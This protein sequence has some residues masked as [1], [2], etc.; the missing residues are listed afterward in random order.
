MT[1]PP[2]H[3]RLSLTRLF[4]FYAG[5]V[6][7]LFLFSL[8]SH[9]ALHTTVNTFEDITEREF[10][11]LRR[12]FFLQDAMHETVLPVL[13]HIAWGNPGEAQ[14]FEQRVQE[15]EEV[16]AD[17]LAMESMGSEQRELI[18]AAR[19]HW[20]DGVAVGRSMFTMPSGDTAALQEAEQSF[21]GHISAC[22]ASLY[23]AHNVRIADTTR[24]KEAAIEW[25]GMVLVIAAISIIAAGIA[26]VFAVLILLRHIIRPL[27]IL[28]DGIQRI[29]A[30]DLSSR[31]AL[32]VDN[33]LGEL[34]DGINRMAAR[35]ARDQ[36]ELEQLATRDCLTDLYNR[37]EFDRLL[38]EEMHRAARYRHPLSMLLID[39]DRFKEINDTLGHRAGDHA[40][41]RVAG[42]IRDISR[43]GDIVARYGGDEIAALLPET[44]A[45]DAVVLA[46]R[47]RRL[48]SQQYVEAGNGTRLGLTLS[49]GVA[50]TSQEIASGEKLVDA[51]DTALYAAKT[52]GR[53]CVRRGGLP[54]Q[55][56]LPLTMP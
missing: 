37:R 24:E 9:L 43:K 11:E 32:K 52:D 12:M 47:I 3:K 26:F 22:V 23:E 28:R 4:A 8:P 42:V 54:P 34:A 19:R 33:E 27:K 46:E 55:A 40:L 29:G 15:V 5:L 50:S 20:Q 14:A 53:N 18:L 44:P 31:I 56:D 1:R 25:H 49:I 17:V 2:R 38:F 35:L 41:R 13:Q 16:F 21:M 39:V 10:V 30:G 36:V 51:A 48:V 7:L 45:E 6:M